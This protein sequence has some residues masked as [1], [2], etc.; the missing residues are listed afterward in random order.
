MA[1]Q[2]TTTRQCREC[3]EAKNL[4]EFPVTRG[5]QFHKCKRCTYQKTQEWA[6]ANR[7][8]SREI[9]DSYVQRNPERN[10]E[11]KTRYYRTE[12]GRAKNKAWKSEHREQI[13]ARNRELFAAKH[14]PMLARLERRGARE[15]QSEGRFTKRD[16]QRLFAE[17]GGKCAGCGSDLAGV[18]HVD[19]ILPLVLGGTHWPENRQILCP[20]CNHQKGTKTPEEWDQMKPLA[21][22]AR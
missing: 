4:S 6:V 20:T 2:D 13:N 10:R 19:H 17:Q 14:E 21:K 5:R 11:S 18:Y 8:R 1:E 15:A 9:K 7:Q 3:G 12:H 22:K 16:K